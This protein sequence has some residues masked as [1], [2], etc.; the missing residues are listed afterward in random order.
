MKTYNIRLNDYYKIKC[1]IWIIYK[2]L[3]EI[4]Y[5]LDKYEK[6]YNELLKLDY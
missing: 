3:A 1:N 2:E 4:Y 6:A 5:H